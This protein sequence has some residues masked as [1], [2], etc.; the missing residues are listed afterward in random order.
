[1]SVKK[2]FA[3]IGIV[4]G[5][6]AVFVGG[7][8]GVMAIM[9]KFKTPEV[10]PEKIYFENSEQVIVAQ[11]ED[12]NNKDVIYSFVLKGENNS[13]DVDV[14]IRECLIWFDKGKDL[15]TLCDKDGKPLTSNNQDRY[16]VNCN[17]TIYYK[18]QAYDED[19]TLDPE[20]T[21]N[22]KVVLKARTSDGLKEASED[23]TIWIDRSVTSVFLSYGNIPE[24]IKGQALEQTINIGK[25]SEV[26]FDYIVNPEISLQPIS[27]E[28]AKV[29]ELYYDEPSTDDYVLVN[30]ENIKN[31]SYN[32]KNLFDVAKTEETGKLVFKSS[33]VTNGNYHQF[34]IAIFPTYNQRDE[35]LSLLPKEGEDNARRIGNMLTTSLSVAVVNSSV[36]R[37]TMGTGTVNLHLFSQND[38]IY[39]HN[40]EEDNNLNVLMEYEGQNTNIRYDEV[41]FD[42]IKPSRFSGS[43]VFERETEQAGVLKEIDFSKYTVTNFSGNSITLKEKDSIKTISLSSVN[44]S[45]TIDGYT[46][47]NSFVYDGA[48]YYCKNGIAFI[49]ESDKDVKLLNSGSYLDFYI[50]EGNNPY[51][52]VKTTDSDIK[53]SVEKSGSGANS[54]W[55]IVIEKISDEILDG[56]QDLVL[57][58]MVANND[59]KFNATNMFATK[60]AKVNIDDLTYSQTKTEQTLKYVV[61]NVQ[62]E[63]YAFETFFEIGGGSYNACVLCISE[64]DLTNA[65]VE[66]INAY[67]TIDETK[68]YVVGYFNGEDFVNSVKVKNNENITKDTTNQLYLLQLKNEYNQLTGKQQTAVELISEKCKGID[69]NA[70]ELDISDSV[71]NLFITQDVEVKQNLYLNADAVSF[72]VQI[73]NKSDPP[74]SLYEQSNHY[75][76]LTSQTSNLIKRI[77]DFYVINND[78]I[79]NYININYNT[80]INITNF[81]N[82]EIKGVPDENILILEFSVGDT[83]AGNPSVT[84]SLKDLTLDSSPI[85]L[86]SF[87]ISSSAP[88]SIIYYYYDEDND[89]NI[90]T[91]TDQD[92]VNIP[93]IT[94]KIGWDNTQKD[95]TT[96]WLIGETELTDGIRL[97]DKLSENES[98]FQ[99]PTF[100]IAHKI[101]YKIE[102]SSVE[103]VTSEGDKYLKV[104]GSGDSFLNVTILGVSKYLK[105][106]VD[107]SEFA[108]TKTSNT[109]TGTSDS[110]GNLIDYKYNN[111]SIYDCNLIEMSN[112]SYSHTNALEF[113][114]QDDEITLKDENDNI[115]LTIKVDN[116]VTKDWTFVR[117][118]NAYSA[119]SISFTITTLTNTLDLN[120]TFEQDVVHEYN[121]Y[122]WSN[123]IDNNKIYLYQG[124]TILLYEIATESRF[125]YEP[126]IKIWRK[127]ASEVTVTADGLT[128]N[129][130]HEVELKNCGNYTVDISLGTGA[131]KTSIGSYVIT[132]IPNIAVIQNDES[133]EIA[134]NYTSIIDFVELKSYPTTKG[135]DTLVYGETKVDIDNKES[136]LL[137]SSYYNMIEI[138]MGEG[139]NVEF[140]SGDNILTKDVNS[141]DVKTNWIEKIGESK[142]VTVTVTSNKYTVGSFN[143]VVKNKFKVEKQ[144]GVTATNN[145][146]NIKAMTDINDWLQVTGINNFT[147][148]NINWKY[149]TADDNKQ[150]NYTSTTIIPESNITYNNVTLLLTFTG[151]VD[152]EQKTLTFEGK[153][154]DLTINIVPYEL[155]SKDEIKAYS[156]NNFNLLTDVYKIENINTYLNTYYKSITVNSVKDANGNNLTNSTLGYV[157]FNT[158][159]IITFNDIVGDSVPAN[160]SYTVEYVGGTTYTYTKEITLFNNE[161]LIVT[162]PEDTRSANATQTEYAFTNVEF[163]KDSENSYSQN[164][165][166]CEPVLVNSTTGTTI[167]LLNDTNKFVNRISAKDRTTGEDKQLTLTSIELFAYQNSLNLGAYAKENVSVDNANGTITFQTFQATISGLLVFK[168]SSTSGNFCYYYVYVHSNGVKNTDINANSYGYVNYEILAENTLTLKD[169]LYTTYIGDKFFDQTFKVDLENVNVY[170]LNA[171]A[172]GDN[173]TEFKNVLTKGESSATR[174]TCVD[175]Y[176]LDI[177]DYTT[178]TLS[179]IYKDDSN[180]YPVGRVTVYARP[181]GAP[182]ETGEGKDLDANYSNETANNFNG[183]YTYKI[184]ANATEISYPTDYSVTKIYEGTNCVEDYKIKE[185]IDNGSGILMS[186]TQITQDDTYSKIKL[187]KGTTDYTFTVFYN[188]EGLT[189]KVIY[190]YKALIIPTTVVT[191]VGDLVVGS[192]ESEQEINANTKFNNSVTFDYD[193]DNSNCTFTK[194]FG[195]Y[196]GEI[197]IGGVQFNIGAD[198]KIST[199]DTSNQIKDTNNQTISYAI[200]EAGVLTLTFTQTTSQYIQNVEF[201]FATKENTTITHA[202]NILSGLKIVTTATSNSGTSSAQRIESTLMLKKEND[203]T[204][205]SVGSTISFVRA[206]IDEY[207][208][209]TT[210][211]VKYE[212]GGYTI[213]IN[214]TSGKLKFS[215]S[216]DNYSNV[217]AD[218]SY[219]LENNGTSWETLKKSNKNSIEVAIE[220]EKFN[221]VHLAQEK[222]IDVTFTI[223]NGESNF[224]LSG[225]D[226]TQTL[227]VKIAK[228]YSEINSTY[229]TAPQ[230]IDGTT[231][232][233]QAENVLKDST[234]GG[235]ADYKING[236][237]AV[238]LGAYLFTSLTDKADYLNYTRTKVTLLYKDNGKTKTKEIYN[239]FSNIGFIDPKNPNFVKFELSDG[240]Q[241]TISTNDDGSQNITF[242]SATLTTNVLCAVLMSNKAGM[243]TKEYNFNIMADTQKDGIT[244]SDQ[245]YV[246][247]DKTYMSFV[248][249]DTNQYSNYS[250]D[251]LLIGSINDNLGAGVFVIDSSLDKEYKFLPKYDAGEVS[252]KIAH[253]TNYN[254]DIIFK[255]DESDAT[256]YNIYLQYNRASGKECLSE[257]TTITLNIYG[258]TDFILN[259]FN[260]KLYNINIEEKFTGRESVYG[261]SAINLLSKFFNKKEGGG[262]DNPENLTF[263]LDEEKSKYGSLNPTTS[264]KESEGTLIEFKGETN[265]ILT[266]SVGSSVKIDAVFNVL[267]KQGEDNY[268]HIQNITYSFLLTRNYQFRFNGYEDNSGT[269]EGTPKTEEVYSYETEF[270]LT[271]VKDEETIYF[272][273]VAGVNNCI[274]ISFSDP[275]K[276]TDVTKD[277]YTTLGWSVINVS[278][279]TDTQNAVT[280]TKTKGEQNPDDSV[281]KIDSVNGQV[282]F[283]Q[284]YTGYLYLTMSMTFTNG[285]TYSVN[286]TIHVHGI[287]TT[288]PTLDNNSSYL[289]NS[290][291]AFKSGEQV[292][293]T[294]GSGKGLGLKITQ[295]D[296]KTKEVN[297]STLKASGSY[298]VVKNNGDTKTNQ[299]RFESIE[300][301]KRVSLEKTY[302][303]T[304]KE[305]KINLPVV[306]STSGV[307]EYLVIYKISLTYL[308]YTTQDYYIAYRVVNYLDISVATKTVKETVG[309]TEKETTYRGD[310][311][312]VDNGLHKDVQNNKYYL[313]LFNYIETYSQ[314]SDTYSITYKF[315]ASGVGE[316]CATKDFLT[317]ALTNVS[318][319]GDGNLTGTYNSESLTLT[320]QTGNDDTTTYYTSDNVLSVFNLKFTNITEY[321]TFIDS[322]GYV[323]IGKF[324]F[325]LEYILGVGYGIDLTTRYS[326]FEITDDCPTGFADENKDATNKLF[327]NKLEDTDLIIATTEGQPIYTLSHYNATAQAGF[328]LTANTSLVAKGGKKISELFNASDVT[329]YTK[330]KDHV[331]VG[332]YSGDT[333]NK[334]FV[335]ENQGSFTISSSSPSKVSDIAIKVP[336]GTKDVNGNDKYLEYELQTVVYSSSSITCSTIYSIQDEFYVIKA[337][338]DEIYRMKVDENLVQGYKAGENT[339]VRLSNLF[340]KFT[341][342]ETNGLVVDTSAKVSVMDEQSSTGIGGDLNKDESGNVIGTELKITEA[343][344]I[345]YKN[346]NPEAKN[347]RVKYSV[348]FDGQSLECTITYGLPENATVVVNQSDLNSNNTV[349]V[350]SLSIPIWKD[351]VLEYKKI[352]EGFNCI[353]IT[354][355]KEISGGGYTPLSLKK[356]YLI[357]LAKSN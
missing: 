122:A 294:G 218:S 34:V 311:I 24:A 303:G 93:T 213:Y 136:I 183:I 31:P 28:S 209:G 353:N 134:S 87:K 270:A 13:Y 192:A 188:K 177:S 176:I 229:V 155:D 163:N 243:P 214:N 6:V 41:V 10:R 256:K 74:T 35:Y 156:N 240:A 3:I 295:T 146:L 276:G 349:D 185:T 259:S 154:D 143:A 308:G 268:I 170:L 102:G 340:I 29:V 297:Y 43:P 260:I 320:K 107:A 20:N 285:T 153:I 130:N 336:T 71:Q 57:G 322:I 239:N 210:H 331:V 352:S 164:V 21:T 162:Y 9:G 106:S 45:I 293:L 95:Y 113:V 196:Q 15:I 16:T 120:L 249:S 319:N 290:G 250:T 138:S 123:S 273:S 300:E 22:G 67:Y 90:L 117:N 235:T 182:S 343:I 64:D 172:L 169:I 133:N 2:V 321:K 286:W 178:L 4:M 291:S 357:I 147:I 323:N 88:E 269:E 252:C 262:Y 81:G 60:I 111:E 186:N 207:A 115:Y 159:L 313:V 141:A 283:Y 195:T 109:I 84:I 149:S 238:S 204:I 132:V 211:G 61:G 325:K 70:E 5:C 8:L 265:E 152:E 89:N 165:E 282:I 289:G 346:A 347:V 221:F 281:I 38:K 14:N 309:G 330:F 173:N 11:Y 73:D 142:D 39:L 72:N 131:N 287:L 345:A 280:I 236:N 189:L 258:S 284:D 168:I 318:I 50:R 82:L 69:L 219:V 261:D 129:G 335:K 96:K 316:Y 58:L 191:Q 140:S 121:S 337:D 245:G 7:V 205:T 324:Y 198:N 44:T 227:Y 114:I 329:N 263:T 344:L 19:Q 201:K 23:L 49:R 99:D 246:D 254:Y 232:L 47:I 304:D 62:Q 251:K 302:S 105:I 242:T 222:E 225:A 301:N 348:T 181:N 46:I 350:S 128:I 108:L 145:V 52:Y 253:N 167:N 315:D 317:E 298:V 144:S 307:E 94:A 148:T 272:T 112:F 216:D 197:T 63:E 125:D 174:Y 40:S 124:T 25:D 299:E 103:I 327:K 206:E 100:K 264:L 277:Y 356:I 68:Y 166:K 255:R 184:D 56:T 224:T 266:K 305:Y 77:V 208:D 338:T 33:I 116:N 306:P 30:L 1:M 158:G 230:N 202:F 275:E 355:I 217:Y 351:S 278:D 48:T 279:N 55:N 326:K 314:G 332:V 160:I 212:F 26:E 51:T 137:Y 36:D 54:Y 27:K 32:L 231:Y 228:S 92:D 339:V 203:E 179:L 78:N 288:T 66:Y 42:G 226:V 101:T 86:C 241:A 248:I 234:I 274:A 98:G 118:F 334:T 79:N 328:R 292:C 223:S 215:F 80:N 150:T 237:N 190:T 85:E 17:E 126:L 247:E 157:D 91:L 83:I 296:T 271:N 267:Y 59:G 37:V 310:D 199:T 257:E 187:K 65:L 18:L 135:K 119:L 161:E 175:E 333:F 312:N 354:E 194:Y 220:D 151:M 200:S 139:D 104:N 75:L 180:I 127:G 342:D 244:F 233:P 12:D 97:N 53:Y 171:T 193:A 341:N 76:V 110:L